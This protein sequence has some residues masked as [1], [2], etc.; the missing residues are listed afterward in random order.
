LIIDSLRAPLLDAYLMT[1][2][3][4]PIDVA[5]PISLENGIAAE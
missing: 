4:L 3:N 2:E 5:L 1:G